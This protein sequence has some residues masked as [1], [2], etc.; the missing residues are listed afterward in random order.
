MKIGFVGGL[1]RNE[2][3]FA[4]IAT[5]AGHEL[6]FHSGIVKGRG[7]DELQ[8]LVSRSEFVII[9]TAINS[10]HGV[11]IAKKTASKMNLPTVVMTKCGRQTFRELLCRASRIDEQI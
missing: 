7:S 4:K 2:S 11:Q 10:H 3:Q 1:T 8:K 5:E 6:E 9:L